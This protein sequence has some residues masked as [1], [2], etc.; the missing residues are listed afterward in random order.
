MHTCIYACMR[1]CIYAYMRICVHAY[2]HIRMYAYMR[3]CIYAYMCTCVWRVCVY[4]HMRVCAY[5]Y[6]RIC[7]CAY[8]RQT[9]TNASVRESAYMHIHVYNYDMDACMRIC[10]YAYVRIQDK[11]WQTQ[12]CG[13]C[14]ACGRGRWHAPP[15][16][17]FTT[18]IY[19]QHIDIYNTRDV[20]AH[21]GIYAYTDVGTRQQ[22]RDCL[23]IIVV[24]YGVA[25]I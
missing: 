12:E 15:A 5:A 22:L 24:V 20:Y 16:A 23:Q 6:M 1:V 13:G 3:V 17:R 19:L 7:V 4:A 8:I 10:V 14:A 21:M 11:P 2:M 18:H 25:R 9:L